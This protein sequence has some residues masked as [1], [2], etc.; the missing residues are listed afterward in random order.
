MR[1]R[2]QQYVNENIVRHVSDTLAY[3]QTGEMDRKTMTATFSEKMKEAINF[4]DGELA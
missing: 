4:E 3:S 2:F 1:N